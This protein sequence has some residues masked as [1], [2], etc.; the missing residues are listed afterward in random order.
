METLLNTYQLGL[1]QLENVRQ[2]QR[3]VRRYGHYCAVSLSHSYDY[4]IPDNRAAI[5]RLY[6]I[7]N[8]TDLPKRIHI[9]V[10][11]YGESIVVFIDAFAQLVDTISTF[12]SSFD[13]LDMVPLSSDDM[14]KVTTFKDKRWVMDAV[15][16][17]SSINLYESMLDIV[18]GIDTGTDFNEMFG[19]LAQ[20][21]DT[22]GYSLQ[23]SMVVIDPVIG[24]GETLVENGWNDPIALN[25]FKSEISKMGTWVDKYGASASTGDGAIIANTVQGAIKQAYP[26]HEFDTNKGIDGLFSIMENI[27]TNTLNIPMQY[28]KNTL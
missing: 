18:H 12:Y 14:N 17:I 16:T 26:K 19:P 22:V 7:T 11:N 6:G 24:N 27:A 13:N 23:D 10:N 5:K 28:I 21:F 2:I 20:A 8:I 25:A 3:S 4:R 9:G 1:S 15:D